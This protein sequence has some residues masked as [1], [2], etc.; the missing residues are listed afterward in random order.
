MENITLK[1]ILDATNGTLLTPEISED[2]IVK[3]VISDNRK[4]QAGDLFFAIVGEK[5]DGHSFVN[6]ALNAGAVG[7]IVSKE[8]D[9]KVPGKFYV[10]VPDTLFALGDLASYY[11]MQ[12]QIPIIAVT[13]SVGKTTMKDM[14][15]SVLSEKFNVIATEG[16]YNNNI[17]V[18]R[19]LFR[20]DRN[21]EVAVVEMGMN[22]EGEINYLTRMTHPTM[23]VITN[24]GDAHI[25]NLGSR[26]NIFKA[27][28]EIFNGLSLDGLA[29]MNADDEYLVK[30]KDN[31]DLQKDYRFKW[32]GEDSDADYGALDIDDTLQDGLKFT[33]IV[34]RTRTGIDEK[35]TIKV[36]ARG[37]HMIYPVLAATAVAKKLDMSYEEIIEGIKN[38]KPTAMRM[39]TWNLGNG[40]IIYNDTYN[41]NPQ[42]MKA[43]L[44]TLANTDGSRRIAVLGDMLELGD[45]EEDLHRSV[46]KKAA[47]LSIDTLI[48]IGQRAKYIADEAK[49]GGLMDVTSY[50]DAESAK[51]QLDSLLTDGAV[52]YF[53]ASHAMA[54]EKLAEYCKDR[55]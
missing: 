5:M 13:G 20:I 16:N 31:E 23:A 33:M 2:T 1:Q 51:D 8:P 36:P 41:A 38:Y 37:R 25:G 22:H 21:T 18:P 6:P 24:I 4:A 9:E 53:K 49:K 46:G 11:R 17:G 35:D 15:A 7:A 28:C 40:I 34:R 26:E 48:T 29:V 43:G 50:D 19:T 47:D 10:L 32:V 52:I 27:K 39:E 54:L 12:F 44:S 14:I 55:I 30:L 3:R 42:S 45:L